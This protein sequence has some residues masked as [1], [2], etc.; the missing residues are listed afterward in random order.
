MSVWTICMT[1]FCV[2]L[3]QL[4]YPDACAQCDSYA[5]P[6]AD[7]NCLTKTDIS[8][9]TAHRHFDDGHWHI[10]H[11]DGRSS[12]KSSY[13]II[14]VIY[15]VRSFFSRSIYI[16]IFDYATMKFSL[17][18]FMHVCPHTHTSKRAGRRYRILSIS[19]SVPLLAH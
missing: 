9:S 3:T 8:K 19:H 4:S 13:I 5:R 2:R 14:Y 12:I 15:I 11:M 18:C 6:S 7:T 1:V 16:Y 17:S 10:L